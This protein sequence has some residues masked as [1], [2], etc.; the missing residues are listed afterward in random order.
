MWRL[1]APRFEDAYRVITF[2]HVGAG[3][4][5]PRAY[6]RDRYSSLDGYADDVLAIVHELDLTDVV[7]VGHS[8][9]AMI[10]VLAAVAEPDRFARLVLIGPSPRYLDDDGYTGGFS[11]ADIAELLESLDSNYLGWSRAMAPVRFCTAVLVRLRREGAGWRATVAS[12]GHPLPLLRRH[13]QASRPVG[14]YGHVLGIM[15]RPAFVDTA[16]ELGPGDALVLFTDGVTEGR[17]GSRLYGAER[18]ADAV[19]A[20]RATAADTTGA[21]LADALAFQAGDPRDDIAVVTVAVDAGPPAP[22]A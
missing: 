4:S 10:G 14:A 18:L 5:D 16:L 21:V 17:R 2:D 20:H 6:D 11:A 19:D 22:P 12:G 8:V 7:L 13:G 1:V 9:S 15:P 3:G